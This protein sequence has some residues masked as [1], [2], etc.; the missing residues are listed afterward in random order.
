[1]DATISK[2]N[3]DVSC[4]LTQQ[5]ESISQTNQVVNEEKSAN[6]SRCEQMNA[7]TVAFDSKFSDVPS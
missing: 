1:M 3:Q 6:E 2:L 5:R 4:R 7:K